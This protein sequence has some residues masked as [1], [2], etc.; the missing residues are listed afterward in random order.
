MT[1]APQDLRG[2]H[3]HAVQSIDHLW[4]REGET[5]KNDAHTYNRYGVQLGTKVPLWG[6]FSGGGKFVLRLWT[7]RPKMKQEDWAKSQQEVVEAA[8]STAAAAMATTAA[9][10]RHNIAPEYWPRLQSSD[11]VG[12]LVTSGIWDPAAY[13][14][15]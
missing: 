4:L 8:V 6:G 2:R 5:M 11:L 3:L 9:A 13:P 1:K 7:P 12:K 10:W 15:P 14:R